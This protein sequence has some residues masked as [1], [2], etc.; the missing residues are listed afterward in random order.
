MSIFSSC[1]R[2][3]LAGVVLTVSSTSQ[4]GV[5]EDLLAQYRA[6]VQA[7]TGA[8]NGWSGARGQALHTQ[9][10]NGG[11]ANTPSCTTCHGADVRAPGRTLTGKPLEAMA[12]S[13][14]P[15]RY[16]DAA[17]VEKW[18]QRNC[19]EV[20]GRACSAQEKGDWLTFMLT[21]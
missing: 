10:L 9:K 13:A 21:Q 17:K 11:K 1:L 8:W 5:R 7:E 6:A 19:N 20:L 2:A 18:F 3:T 4:A 12:A 14:A 15:N 16:T